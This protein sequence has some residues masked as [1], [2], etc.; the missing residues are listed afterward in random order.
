MLGSSE[1]GTYS[2]A[3]RFNEL[4]VRP[5]FVRKYTLQELRENRM[6]MRRIT[7]EALNRDNGHLTRQISSDET[8]VSSTSTAQPL[9]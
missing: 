1:G 2:A 7:S 3:S 6:S 8:S 9:L 5:L 4:F